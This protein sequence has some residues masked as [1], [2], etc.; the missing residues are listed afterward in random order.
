MEKD[1]WKGCMERMCG[2]VVGKESVDR[3]YGK[4]G[5]DVWYV[6]WKGLMERMYVNVVCCMERIN[7]K[8]VCKSCIGRL[9]RKVVWKG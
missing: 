6:V 8:D 7:G 9:Y 4:D 1:V 2:Q 3:L 5:N